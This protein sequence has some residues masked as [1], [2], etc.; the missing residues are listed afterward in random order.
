MSPPTAPGFMHEGQ[1]GEVWTG[2]RGGETTQRQP[3][4]NMYYFKREV[5]TWLKIAVRRWV[6][7]R[8]VTARAQGGEE[9]TN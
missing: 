4:Q 6:G 3:L 9:K 5:T 2:E 7:L 8:A 1:G